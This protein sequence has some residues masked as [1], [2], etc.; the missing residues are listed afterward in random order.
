MPAETP[1][2]T[3][4]VT[5]QPPPL[6]DYDVFAADAAL[7]EAVD[8]QVAPE[9]AG[10]VRAELSALGRAAGSAE[11]QEW[12]VQA[13]ECAPRLR[14]HDRY[15]H[16]IDEV[17]F[18]PAWHHL[19][20]RAVSAGLTDA[21]SRPDGHL[22]RAAGFLVWSQVEAGHGCPVSMTHAAVP[23]LRAEPRLA[24]QWEPL[25]T[26]HVYEPGLRAP[27]A[28]RGALAGMGMTEKQGGSDV[29]AN[30]TWAAPLAEDGTYALR[31]HKWFCSAPMSDVFLVLAQ[32]EA[33]LTCFLV[34]RVLAD[35][36]R[37]TFRVQR[38]KDKLGNRSN[39]SGEVEFDG[40]TWAHRVGEEGRGVATIIE[41]V[42]ATRLDCVLG[43]AGLMR[44]AVAQAVHHT[45]HRE[46]F[47][48]L[49][50]DKPLMRNVL[51]DLAVESE[52]ATAL[53]LRLAAACDAAPE[54]EGER[55]LLRL[56]VPAAKYWVTKRCTPTVGEALECLGGNG[57]VEESGMPR[58]LR[59]APL[60]SIWEGSGNVQALDV[61]RALQREPGALD[62]FLG[63]V[64][65]ARGAD[66]RLDAAVKDLLVELADLEGIEGRA[67]RLVE[68]MALVLQGA[69]LVRHAP[70][71]VADAF[72]ASRLGADWG[73]AFGTLPG[74][75]D[76][77]AVV[78]RARPVA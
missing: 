57:Y 35:G 50:V 67:R 20:D 32:A 41:M 68:R 52:A 31:G 25:L 75:L 60:N 17:D 61:L 33:G 49:L 73:H 12:G 47:G 42:A 23:A 7:A 43:S 45:A 62:A 11:A 59:E 14:T 72:C 13:N 22:R 8:R 19:L 54:D 69:L 30:T 1:H 48:G 28:K 55:L 53:A 44:Q 36:S 77:A 58:L 18:H 51:A 26:S 71:E 3:H 10:E 74:T 64:G 15:G 4:S 2:A 63:E 21:W 46:A 24:A 70:A 78:E 9:R 6:V 66:H 40:T 56:A 38:L 29:R 16:R 34:P 37:N 39:A 76:L 5:N 65:A 27:A